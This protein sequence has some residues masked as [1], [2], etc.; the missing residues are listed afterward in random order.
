ML[1][2]TASSISQATI[3]LLKH[4]R[5]MVT[6][7]I[8]YALLLTGIYVFVNTK[9][10]TTN[11]V[12]ISAA[13]TFAVPLLFFT[14]QTASA[15]YTTG[16]RLERLIVGSI[17]NSWKLIVV[18]VPAIALTI[19]MVYLLNRVQTHVGP[20]ALISTVDPNSVPSLAQTQRPTLQWSTIVL[21]TLRYLCLGFVAPLVLVRLWIHAGREGLKTTFRRFFPHLKGSFAASS[22]LIYMAG[23]SVFAVLPYFLL[24][25]STTITTAWLEIG[26]FA[27]RLT[28]VFFLTLLGWVVTVGALSLSA[29]AVSTR[30]K[31]APCQ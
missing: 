4:W 11:Q 15:C 7:G 6:M 10:A 1:R 14:L 29:S 2:I 8:M 13:L 27:L 9:E 25:K 5:V 20:G 3:Q 31:E 22:I 16:Q 19:L 21:S 26:V 18:S 24:F 17:T 12:L 28:L 23:F 30:T